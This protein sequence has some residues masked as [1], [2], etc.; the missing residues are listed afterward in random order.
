[1]CETYRAVKIGDLNGTGGG[2]G[3]SMVKEIQQIELEQLPHRVLRDDECVPPDLIE[4][5]SINPISGDFLCRFGYLGAK[6]IC[7]KEVALYI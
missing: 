1:M 4:F 5:I 6:I 3:S 2:P 7:H